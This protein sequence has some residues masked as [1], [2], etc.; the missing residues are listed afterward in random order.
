MICGHD[1]DQVM[2]HGTHGVMG[3]KLSHVCSMYSP[4]Q[5]GQT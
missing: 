3:L 4:S 5:V 1:C 2:G